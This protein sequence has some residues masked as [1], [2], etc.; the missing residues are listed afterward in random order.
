MLR[1]D[2][3]HHTKHGYSEAEPSNRLAMNQSLDARRDLHARRTARYDLNLPHRGARTQFVL[4][5]LVPML[6]AFGGGSVLH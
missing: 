4:V 1:S 3:D 2:K 6:V 5:L